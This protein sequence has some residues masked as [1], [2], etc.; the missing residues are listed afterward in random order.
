MKPPQNGN[1]GLSCTVTDL[2]F[3]G[4]VVRVALETDD[5]RETIAHVGADEQLPMLRPGD[6]VW[7]GWERDAA[8]LLPVGRVDTTELDVPVGEVS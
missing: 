6:T 2:V 1:V 4:P 7:A 3:Q 5:G 8:R